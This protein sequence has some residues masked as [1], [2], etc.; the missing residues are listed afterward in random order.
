MDSSNHKSNGRPPRDRREPSLILT[1]D[2]RNRNFVALVLGAEVDL[3]TTL[4]DTLLDL[5]AARLTTETGYTKLRFTGGDEELART[6]ISRLRHRIDGAIRPGAGK[7][8]IETGAGTE[9][10]LRLSRKDIEVRDAFFTELPPQSVP[11]ELL[12]ILKR[13]TLWYGAVT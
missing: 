11:T 3:P 1:G 6:Q 13:E 2:R 5:V 12:D 7:G 4:F 9:Y 10:R 8:L